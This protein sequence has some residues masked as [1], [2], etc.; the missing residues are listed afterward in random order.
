MKL[1]LNLGR[2][3]SMEFGFRMNTDDG[4]EE[5][6]DGQALPLS[7]PEFQLAYLM[8]NYPS[9]HVESVDVES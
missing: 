5:G 8:G 3:D 2:N 7:L 4:S 1:K 9:N 6:L